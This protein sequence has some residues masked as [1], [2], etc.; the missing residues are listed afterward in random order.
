MM[1]VVKIKETSCSPS[2]WSIKM[3]AARILCNLTGFDLRIHTM[4]LQSKL[5]FYWK[6]LKTI[7]FQSL[8]HKRHRRTGF[9]YYC[10]V[11]VEN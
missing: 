1:R 10:A 9:V 7:I 11:F 8:V 3:T 4:K 6:W 2:S 5:C